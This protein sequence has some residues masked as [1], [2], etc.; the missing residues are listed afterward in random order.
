MPNSTKV[1]IVPAEL[2]RFYDTKPKESGGPASAVNAVAGED[3]GAGLLKYYFE[4]VERASVTILPEKP[5]SVK[6]ETT[7]KASW[8]DLWLLVEWPDRKI[9]FQVEIKNWSAHSVGGRALTLSASPEQ[10]KAYKI[11]SWKREWNEELT[12]NGTKKV[13]L[14]MISPERHDDTTIE[15]LLCMWAAMHPAGERDPFYNVKVPDGHH[16]TRLWVFSMSAYLRMLTCHY[17]EMEMPKTIE[18]QRVLNSL[19]QKIALCGC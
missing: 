17:L 15:P 7:G 14:P 16:F 8:L 1:R 6:S 9:L 18:R 10:I 19:F 3:L 13:L 4:N 5:K 2:V 12:Q 11:N